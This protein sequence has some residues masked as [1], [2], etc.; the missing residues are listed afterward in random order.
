MIVYCNDRV[1]ADSIKVADSFWTRFR[2]LM[3]RKSLTSGEGLLLMH[4]PSVHCFF[5]KIPI[6]A[7]HLSK[8]MTVLGIET[9]PPWSVGRSIKGTAHILELKAGNTL[10]SAGDVLKFHDNGGK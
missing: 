7:V 9:L 1:L 8:D 3:G 2:G 4:C 5:M 10:V 6:D